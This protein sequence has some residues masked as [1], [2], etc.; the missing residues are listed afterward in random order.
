MRPQL[1]LQVQHPIEDAVCRAQN[2]GTG[3]LTVF[4]GECHG[5]EAGG[6]AEHHPVLPGL[7]TV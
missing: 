5:K 3:N 6:M 4:E 7:R 1:G 2:V